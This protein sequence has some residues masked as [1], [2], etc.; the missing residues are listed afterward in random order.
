MPLAEIRSDGGTSDGLEQVIILGQE[1][2]AFMKGLREEMRLPAERF[3]GDYLNRQERKPS[4]I[5]QLP[6]KWRTDVVTCAWDGWR[7]ERKKGAN[8]Q[9]GEKQ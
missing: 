3:A 5:H 8:N 6:E 2:C 9:K 4:W 7:M 1:L